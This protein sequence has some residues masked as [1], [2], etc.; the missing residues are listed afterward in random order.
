MDPKFAINPIV[1][2]IPKPII[3][4]ESLYAF[5]MVPANKD[6]MSMNILTT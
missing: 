3:G 6:E 5:R 4:L 2:M 1:N